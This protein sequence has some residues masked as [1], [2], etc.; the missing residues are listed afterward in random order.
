MRYPLPAL[1]P[2]LVMLVATAPAPADAPV[3]PVTK[4]PV[5]LTTRTPLG[6]ARIELPAGSQVD[7]NLVSDQKVFISRP[8]FSAWVPVKDTTLLTDPKTTPP[9]PPTEASKPATPPV[10]ALPSK[11]TYPPG[12]MAGWIQSRLVGDGHIVVAFCILV[13][14]ACGSIIVS[15]IC[16]VLLKNRYFLAKITP[17]SRAE[18][19][20]ASRHAI[21]IKE[22]NKLL[23]DEKNR[24]K[25]EIELLKGTLKEA[26]EKAN[27]TLKDLESLENKSKSLAEKLE[28]ES[29]RANELGNRVSSQ[30]AELKE[31]RK[32]LDEEKRPIAPAFSSPPLPGMPD[33]NCPLC[34]APIPHQSLSLGVNV[35]PSCKGEFN[36]E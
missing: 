35:C 18:K 8:P 33:V 30:D 22:L 10:Q 14:L 16:F 21:E 6:D 15:L 2:G 24:S 19:E 32:K 9:Q 31:L 23:Q 3:M 20:M 36:C 25:E 11:P 7:S 34:Q 27:K 5:V 4:I 12:S 28:K 29:S 17:K 26:E 13:F 1:L